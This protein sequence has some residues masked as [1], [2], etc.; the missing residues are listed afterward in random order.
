MKRPTRRRF[1]A[2]GIV[3]PI[4]A[5][6]GRGNAWRFFTVEE[7]RTLEAVCGQIIPE[8]QD[9]GAVKGGAVHFIDTQLTRFYRPLQKIYRHGIAQINQAGIEVGGKPFADLP[10]EGQLAVLRRIESNP[11][12]KPFFDLLVAHTMQ[13]FYGDPRHGGNRDRVSWKMLR[14]P[15]PPVRGRLRYDLTDPAK[16]EAPWG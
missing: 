4:T 3:A 7:A 13:G 10:A 6:G 14:L 11:E 1:I 8:D 12:L 5:C 16:G 15:Y 9:P 2:A